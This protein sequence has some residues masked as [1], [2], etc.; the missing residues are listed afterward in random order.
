MGHSYLLEAYQPTRV[1]LRLQ[2]YGCLIGMPSKKTAS[3]QIRERNS[4]ENTSACDL[5]DTS[6]QA[7]ITYFTSDICCHGGRFE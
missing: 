6:L 4:R 5:G 7:Q 2:L 3:F 1:T